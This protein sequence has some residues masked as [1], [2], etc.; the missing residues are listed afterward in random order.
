MAVNLILNDLTTLVNSSAITELNTNFTKIETEFDKVL[1]KDGREELTSNL[2]LNGFRILN[3]AAPINPTDFIR[4]QDVPA[5]G[6]AATTA[7][8]NSKT[9][10]ATLLSSAGAAA[11][12]FLQAGLNSVLRTLQAKTAETPSVSDFT[13]PQAAVDACILSGRALFVDAMFT[14]TTPLVISGPLRIFAP[15][16]GDP[17]SNGFNRTGAGDLIQITAANSVTVSGLYLLH[18]GTSGEVVKITTGESHEVSDCELRAT[19]V[20]GTGTM[21]TFRG[22]NTYIENNRFTNLRAGQYTIVMDRT[23]GLININSAIRENYF[24]GTGKGILVHSSDASPRPEGLEFSQNACILT[25]GYQLE[26]RA[27][28]GLRFSNNMMDQAIDGCVYFNPDIG[29]VEGI[30]IAGPNFLSTASEATGV[31]GGVAIGVNAAAA[32]KLVDISVS[33]PNTISQSAY[34]ISFPANVEGF[35]IDGATFSTIDQTA[36]NI[37]QAKTGI[38]QNN[39]YRN[40][41]SNMAIADGAAGGPYNILGNQFQSSA[42]LTITATDKSKFNWRDNTGKKTSGWSSAATP[43]ISAGTSSYLAVPHGLTATPSIDRIVAS[44]LEVSGGFTGVSCKI[45]TID[46]TNITFEL[47]YTVVT[48]GVLRINVWCEL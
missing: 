31:S 39:Q 43:T 9:S 34:G 30:D 33:G 20:T 36:L 38:I 6:D 42:A 35:K 18:S 13:T 11:V 47:Y 48:A 16:G 19:N 12:G 21:L 46:A 40:L 25:G 29:N 26:I 1:Y 2:D 14:L 32:G 44:V 22:S 27:L 8:I 41:T 28:L 7:L 5:L 23:A 15:A 10:I 37:Q 4:L 24:G 17:F 45:D 3:S